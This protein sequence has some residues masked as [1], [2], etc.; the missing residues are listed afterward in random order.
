MDHGQYESVVKFLDILKDSE[1]DRKAM[2]DAVAI[3]ASDIHLAQLQ[4][5]TIH[6][7]SEE[8]ENERSTAVNLYSRYDTK[9]LNSPDFKEEIPLDN[10]SGTA[11]FSYWI[12]EEGK[13]DGRLDEESIN[14]MRMLSRIINLNIGRY[15][16]LVLEKDAQTHDMASGVYNATGYIAEG[17]KLIDAGKADQYTAVYLNV[18]KFKLINQ[19]Y[20]HGIGNIALTEIARNLS[21][22]LAELGQSQLVGRLGGDNFVALMKDH[23]FDEF[24]EKINDMIVHVAE[25]GRELDIPITFFVG[26]YKLTAGDQDM[27]IVMENSSVAYSMAR[28][29]EQ[30]EPVFYDEELHKRILRE[31]EIE[32]RMRGA[33]EN[34]EFA[35]YYQPKVDL[36]TYELNGA[37]ALVRWLDNGRVVPPVEF[38]PLFERNGFICNIDFYVLNNVCRSVRNW[39]DRGI[40]VIPISVNFSRAHFANTRFTEQIVEVVKKYRVPARYIEIEFTES[41][42]FQ[43]KERLVKAVEY[44]KSY[45]I[46]T[47]MDDFGTGFSSLSLLKTLPVDVLKIDKSLLDSETNQERIIIS[48]VVRMVQEMNIKVITEGVETEEQAGF[49]KNINCSNAQG[50][51]F[52]KPLPIDEFEV[53][54]QK[55]HY[56]KKELKQN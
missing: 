11:V 13:A 25:S 42:D 43:D 5:Y 7:S 28:H 3:F 51:L 56:E 10:G 6:E 1:G 2:Q 22:I 39:L 23:V 40:D 21:M 31:K 9:L 17:Q 8:L 44:L 52:D 32:S 33:L 48:N 46:A 35:V 29:K 47:S 54:L 30:T 16:R 4:E 24:L 37:E 45:G 36:D 53:R 20:G 55:G 15:I 26:V 34:K 50:Y 19:M 38:V 18:S 12:E 49:L 41:V 27:S 14:V